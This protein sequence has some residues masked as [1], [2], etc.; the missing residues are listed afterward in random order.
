MKFTEMSWVKDFREFANETS[1]HGVKNIFEGPSKIVKIL[2][3]LV[4]ITLTIYSCSVIV[5]SIVRY[6]NR[7]TGT[8]FEVLVES[9]G[10]GEDGEESKRKA[11]KFPT[12]SI[13]SMNK[14]KKSFLDLD[15]NKLLKE[16]WNIMDMY[17]QEEIKKLQERFNDPEDE[18]VKA[19]IPD[20][21]YQ[22]VLDEGGPLI[23]N[24][25]KCEQRARQCNELPGFQETSYVEM[26][27]SITGRCFRVNPS[28][29]LYGKMGDYGSFKLYL[30]ADMKDYS[31]RSKDEP[32]QG[33]QVA[34]HDNTTYGSTMSSGFLMSP[35]TYYKVDLR[36]KKEIR[37]PPP[38][39]NCNASIGI[40]SYG[41]YSE[42][43]CILECKDKALYE[44]CGCVNVVPPL[45]YIDG[46]VDEDGNPVGRYESC[47]F[48]QWVESGQE[49]YINWYTEFTNHSRAEDICDCSTPACEEISYEAQVSSSMISKPYA[50]KTY[51]KTKGFLPLPPF[52]KPDVGIL[53]DSADDIL[54]NVMAL[55]VLF[56]SMQTSEIRE[57][58]TYTSA[59]L[60]GDIGGV[61][62]LFL[63]ASIFTVLEF[64]QFLFFSIAKHC[65]NLGNKKN[66]GAQRLEDE[67]GG[68]EKEKMAL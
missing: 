3:L 39:G 6:V 53:Y 13:C 68:D 7:P 25:L 41:E 9:D 26:E 5:N 28:G 17:D 65:C 21:K 8:K 10:V 46:K 59:N 40:T 27:S 14:V 33:F 34:F 12:I 61:L 67:N 16:A 37:S 2:F 44:K 55:E 48:K 31:E 24:V 11:I 15:E 56:T 20:I 50:E 49:T 38:S 52:S 45:N 4:W 58:V 60:L 66:S 43:S 19:G 23:S 63:G 29:T 42:G 1:A 57:V 32:K 30:W 64:G 51:E 18:L 47:T 54:E 22:F 36:R 62:G 35:G